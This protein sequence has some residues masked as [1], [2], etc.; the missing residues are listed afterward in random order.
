MPPPEHPRQNHQKISRRDFFGITG[1]LIKNS[2][3]AYGLGSLG[4]DLAIHTPHYDDAFT[5]TGYEPGWLETRNPDRPSFIGSDGMGEKAWL[6]YMS[7]HDPL[8]KKLHTAAFTDLIDLSRKKLTLKDNFIR[9]IYASYEE[10]KHTTAYVHDIA[11]TA[12]F[13]FASVNSNFYTVGEVSDSFSVYD[14]N[15]NLPGDAYF[16]AGVY[17]KNI[18]YVFQHSQL[19]D[20]STMQHFAGFALLSYE[21]AYAKEHDLPE[22]KNIPNLAKLVSKLGTSPADNAYAFAVSGE[23]AWE[24]LESVNALKHSLK[25]KDI[26]KLTAHGYLSSDL[27]LDWKA[28]IAG[29]SF[30]LEL[31][32]EITS[33]D[34]L[35]RRCQVLDTPELL[36]PTHLQ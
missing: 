30:G 8:L 6:R 34:E 26:T 9:F 1:S 3:I 7:T 29:A 27:P 14:T 19:N 23:M 4:I 36:L 18:P 33:G 10:L 28:S 5:A 12:L 20:I 21:F 32:G 35:I 31:Y 25:E 11:H 15:L 13:S 16:D 17:E 2:L 24:F 22:A